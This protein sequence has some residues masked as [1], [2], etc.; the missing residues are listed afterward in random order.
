MESNNTPVQNTTWWITS[1]AISVT[2]CAVLFVIFAGYL[3]DI[4]KNIASEN[5]RLEEMA[6][7]EGQLLNEIQ[8]LR[9][10]MTVTQ[11][12]PVVAPTTVP[13]AVPT[14]VPTATPTKPTETSLPSTPDATKT[15]PVTTPATSPTA[16]PEVPA[17]K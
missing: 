9:H 6:Q 3:A 16:I 8:M 5:L 11:G 14:T 2:C 17:G 15:A 12:S 1:L 4:N 10:N 13:V 7:H